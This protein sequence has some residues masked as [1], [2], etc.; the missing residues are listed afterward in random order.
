MVANPGL[1]PGVV[2]WHL[3]LLFTQ[4]MAFLLQCQSRLY[5]PAHSPAHV[6]G[7]WMRFWRQAVM[8]TFRSLWHST[9]GFLLFSTSWWRRAA[10]AVACHGTS[11]LHYFRLF[12]LSAKSSPQI[13]H[14]ISSDVE[15]RA[16]RKLV[17]GKK[18]MDNFWA[19]TRL[20][21][22]I[23]SLKGPAAFRKLRIAKIESQFQLLDFTLNL[24]LIFRALHNLTLFPITVPGVP[25][26]QR[27]QAPLAALKMEREYQNDLPLGWFES[28][29]G[30]PPDPEMQML[31]GHEEQ[32]HT[33]QLEGYEIVGPDP[34]Q[35]PLV[36]F[37][38]HPISVDDFTE[39]LDFV[40]DSS[41][42]DLGPFSSGL[43]GYPVDPCNL[44][45]INPGVS[46]MPD[47]TLPSSGSSSDGYEGSVNSPELFTN[48]P[49]YDLPMTMM[50]VLTPQDLL[51]AP[52][53]IDYNMHATSDTTVVPQI[54]L[55]QQ[56]YEQPSNVA[57][58]ASS[59]LP[60][61]TSLAPQTPP[62]QRP[63][64]HRPSKKKTN[65]PFTSARELR[66]K[67]RPE[68]CP[69]CGKGFPYQAD[70]DKHIAARHQAEAPKYGVSI[71]SFPCKLCPPSV[72]KSFPRKDRLIRH[73]R[74]K[75]GKPMSGRASKLSSRTVENEGSSLAQ[76]EGRTAL[77]K[78]RPRGS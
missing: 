48:A 75:H 2:R 38:P 57:R 20:P 78:L 42:L 54:P 65:R 11:C 35:L 1:L 73:E 6:E 26:V 41:L 59:P 33:Q 28:V 44:E 74:T 69:E 22:W 49:F 14:G 56:Q 66:K 31:A 52:T 53:L 76:G 67:E 27:L 9:Q 19:R 13:V 32:E 62:P 18:S 30:F 4:L 68:K 70:L 12:S 17:L 64:T 21:T 55:E 7:L 46:T 36:Q 24:H 8:E 3:G 15:D 71:E 58:R 50:P 16:R 77:K 40:H 10:P 43:G 63:R 25:K 23:P 51:V 34:S 45:F 29:C 5:Q 47:L 60:E 72:A 39:N 61:D 37:P